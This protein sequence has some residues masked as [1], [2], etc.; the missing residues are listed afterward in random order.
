MQKIK[1]ALLSYGMSGQVFHAP[2]LHLH[3]GFELKGS[4]ER[5]TRKIESDY[6][7]VRSYPSLDAVLHDDVDLVIVNTPVATHF[8]YAKRALKAGKHVLVEKA[9]TANA[10]EAMELEALADQKGLQLCV[11]QNR[12]WDSDFQLVRNILREGVLG[13]IVEAELHFD[14]YNPNLSPKQHK[15]TQNEGAGILKD[16]GSHLIDQALQLFGFPE[17]VFADLRATR[18]QSVVDDCIDVLLY[19]PQT[20]VRIKA[21]YFVMEPQAAYV[22]HGKKGS[23]LKSRA[24]VQ[25]NDLKAGNRPT[26]HNWG[27]EPAGAEGI[28]HFDKGGIL[29]KKK[30]GAPP[31]NYLHFFEALYQALSTGGDVPV[32]ASDGVK[33]MRIIDAAIQSS[34]TKSYVAL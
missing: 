16:L 11:F 23:F 12:R 13:P 25:E 26:S 17:G 20:R 6:P 4:W 24:D 33:T 9:F 1:T 14:R 28:L 7:G 18:D 22:L 10:A 3:P 5:S 21:G 30:L 19:Y 8:D 31:G 27:Y 34:A 29:E 2:F 32:P 15:E